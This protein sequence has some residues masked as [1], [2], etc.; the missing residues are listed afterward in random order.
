MTPNL[1]TSRPEHDVGH[2]SCYEIEAPLL[3]KK[4]EAL[5]GRSLDETRKTQHE[6]KAVSQTLGIGLLEYI[7]A[8]FLNASEDNQQTSQVRHTHYDTVDVCSTVQEIVALQTKLVATQ[9]D[10]EQRALEED[11]TGKI[12]WF[13]WC[14][15]SSEV[16]QLLPKV[17]DHIWRRPH[18]MSSPPASS[19]D[20]RRCF[21]EIAEIIQNTPHT[22][23]PDYI[24]H[25]QRIMNDAGAGVSRHELWLAARAMEQTKLSRVLESKFVLGSREAALKTSPEI[26]ADSEF[27]QQVILAFPEYAQPVHD[28]CDVVNRY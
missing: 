14:G 13:Y 6:V 17:V 5:G 1:F 19:Y 25:L 2:N 11:I 21:R 23:R 20:P 16:I 4:C 24:A 12:L 26:D 15:I 9:D 18:F 3:L 8:S 28:D 7:R 22:D 27:W 10:D